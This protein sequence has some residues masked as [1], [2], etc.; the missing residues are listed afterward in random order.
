MRYFAMAVFCSSYSVREM[1]GAGGGGGGGGGE[2]GRGGGERGGRRRGGG[3]GDDF[4]VRLT[5]LR[6]M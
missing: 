4:P 1:K 6:T 5:S 2:R 3:A